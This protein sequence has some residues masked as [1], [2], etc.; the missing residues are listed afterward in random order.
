MTTETTIDTNTTHATWTRPLR[1]IWPGL[2]APPWAVLRGAIARRIIRRAV[3]GLPLRVQFPDG[4]LD[5][6]GWRGPTRSWSIH[7]PGRVLRPS[8]HRRQDRLR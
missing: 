6:D 3:A 5:R 4:T 8:R 2:S 7:R 1:P